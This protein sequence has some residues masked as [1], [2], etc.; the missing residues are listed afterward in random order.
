MNTH[1]HTHT[2]THTYIYIYIYIY[3][4]NIYNY[5]IKICVH[6]FMYPLNAS[7]KVTEIKRKWQC[8]ALTNDFIYIKAVSSIITIS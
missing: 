8:L 7:K 3:I 2:H 5:S 4:C 6:V 1:T